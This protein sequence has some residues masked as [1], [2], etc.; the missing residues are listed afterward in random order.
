[1]LGTCSRAAVL[2]AYAAADL[3]VVPSRAETYGLV[4]GE[5]LAAGVPVLATAAG[6]LPEALGSTADGMPGLLIPPEDPAALATALARWLTD[7]GLRRRLRAAALRR[8]ATVP[9]WRSTG[10]RIR[11]VLAAVQAEIGPREARVAR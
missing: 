11:A 1:M 6:G 2:Q 9:D 4:V 3:L 5:A 7:D 8:R 10:A